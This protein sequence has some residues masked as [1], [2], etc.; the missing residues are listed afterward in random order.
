MRALALTALVLASVAAGLSGC[1]QNPNRVAATTQPQLLAVP[2]AVYTPAEMQAMQTALGQYIKDNGANLSKYRPVV[3]GGTILS[4]GTLEGQSFRPGTAMLRQL[5]YLAFD[6]PDVQAWIDP[7][8]AGCIRGRCTFIAHL[9][10]SR[11][12][13]IVPV[14]Y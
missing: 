9:V 7:A 13:L 1:A 3:V 8:P 6:A 5:G 14:D 4:V 2:R 11:Q 10:T 12:N